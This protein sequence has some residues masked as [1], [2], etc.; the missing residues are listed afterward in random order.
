L[1]ILGNIPNQNNTNTTKQH[2]FKKENFAKETF[3]GVILILW[4]GN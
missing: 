4:I 2:F 3:K 1:Y